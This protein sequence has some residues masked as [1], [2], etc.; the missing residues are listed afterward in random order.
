MGDSFQPSWLPMATSMERCA[1]MCAALRKAV[2]AAPGAALAASVRADSSVLPL[3]GTSAE[4]APAR[5]GWAE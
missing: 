1:A 3:R 5:N 4:L 2:A